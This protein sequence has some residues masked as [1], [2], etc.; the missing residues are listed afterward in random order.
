MPSPF[1]GMDPYIESWIWPDFHT[2]MV[3]ELRSQANPQLPKGYFAC[4]E[5]LCRFVA[6][7]PDNPMSAEPDLYVTEGKPARHV[8]GR[9]VPPHTSKLRGTVTK[10]HYIKFVDHSQRRTVSVI[11]LLNPANKTAGKLADAYHHKRNEFIGNN[12]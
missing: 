4:L 5:T 3:V 9:A 10:Q 6:L 11:W 7:S 8:S 1:P 12:V 2:C